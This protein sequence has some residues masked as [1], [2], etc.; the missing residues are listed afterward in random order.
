MLPLGALFLAILFELAI[1]TLRESIPV[2]LVRIGWDAAVTA[3]GLCGAIGSEFVNLTA[4]HGGALIATIDAN[5]G[6]VEMVSLFW[7][8]GCIALLLNIRSRNPGYFL[9]SLSIVIGTLALGVPALQAYLVAG[10]LH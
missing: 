1:P 4:H 5:I 7:A 8:F 6:L 10:S 2:A 3:L 9:G